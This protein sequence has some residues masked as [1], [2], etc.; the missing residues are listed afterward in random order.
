MRRTLLLLLAAM[1]ALLSLAGNASA[2]AD[3]LSGVTVEAPVQHDV[4]IQAL[5]CNSGDVCVWPVTDGSRNRCSWTNRD[6]D[7]QVAPVTCSWSSGSAVMSTYNR[8]TSTSYYGVCLYPGANYT[9]NVGYLVRQ[10]QQAPG[11]PGV[12]IR[13]H[14]WVTGSSCW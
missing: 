5:T 4:S 12:K 8:G 1:M 3:A 9:G 10:G 13:S 2:G 7:W 11:F 14:K 6:N